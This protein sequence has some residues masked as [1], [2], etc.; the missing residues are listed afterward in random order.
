MFLIRHCEEADSELRELN[1]AIAG[2]DS[3]SLFDAITVFSRIE[4]RID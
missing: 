4:L 2:Y 1:A 3:V